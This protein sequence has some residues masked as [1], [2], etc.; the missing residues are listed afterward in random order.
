MK[1]LLLVIISLFVALITTAA[2]LNPYA[3]N[4]SSSYDPSTFTL[5]INYSL[6]APAESVTIVA[7]DSEKNTYTLSQ[8]GAR[9]ASDHTENI[10]LLYS[11]DID[12][13]P[14]NEQLTWRIDVKGKNYNTHQ[15]CGQKISS[16]TPF[17]IGI[18]K[19]P[20]SKYFGRIITSQTNNNFDVGLYSYDPRFQGG[21]VYIDSDVYLGNNQ[22]WYDNTFLTPYRVRI[23]QD[24]SG[25]IFVSSAAVGQPTY[26]WWVNPN[27]LEDWNPLIQSH[28]MKEYAPVGLKNKE[29][30][31]MG[32]IDF[33][34]QVDGDKVNVL[35]FGSSITTGDQ[36][37]TGD[38][39]H[40]G[41]Y[42]CNLSDLSGGSYRAL[43]E[44]NRLGG[45]PHSQITRSNYQSFLNGHAQFDQF[46]GAWF[47]GYGVQSAQFPESPAL[48]HFIDGDASRSQQY[49]DG[50]YIKRKSVGSASIC[51]NNTFDRF[52]ISQG[53][54]ANEARIYNIS[55]ANG[56][57]PVLSDG[58]SVDI[59]TISGTKYVIDM[60]WD[61]ADNLYL[62]VRNRDAALQGVWVVAAALNGEATSTPA[63]VNKGCEFTMGCDGTQYAVTATANDISFGK[64]LVAGTANEF[65]NGDYAACEKLSLAPLPTD[66]HR[67][68]EWRDGNGNVVSSDSIYSFYVSNPTT[69][70]A[71]FEYATYNVE[72]YGLFQNKEDITD[73]SLDAERNARL[74]RLFQVEYNKHA[75]VSQ[76]DKGESIGTSGS[77]RLMYHVL[78]FVNDRFTNYDDANKNK[79]RAL[80]EDFLDNDSD[81]SNLYWLGQYIESVVG[82]EINDQEYVN[83][84]G[85][86][87]QSF[88]NR[89]VKSHNADFSGNASNVGATLIGDYKIV[90]FSEKSKPAYWRP[91]W[92][93]HAC[94]LPKTYN[95]GMGLPKDWNW[96]ELPVGWSIADAANSKTI[97]NPCDTWCKW[98]NQAA[99][100]GKLLGWYYDDKNNPTWPTNPTIVRNVDHSGALFATWVE[101]L[102]SEEETTQH[103][104]DAIFLLNHHNGTHDI[105]V[106]RKMQGGMYNT[107]CLPFSATKAQQPAVLQNATIVQFTGVNE[108]LYDESG[109]PVVELQ[110]TKVDDIVAGVPYLVMP[111]TDIT[112]EMTFTNIL[113]GYNASTPL[114]METAQEITKS[115]NNGSISFIGNIHPTNIPAQSLIVVANN[116]LAEVT[117]AG[118]IQHMRGY[119]RIDDAQLQTLSEEGKVY[120]SMRKPTTTSVP[121]APEAEQ[122]AQPKV[123]KIMRNGKIY[124]LRGDEIYT[125]TGA[126]V[127]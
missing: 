118:D 7:I 120:L 40:S 27:N 58:A 123:Q 75:G 61:Y 59:T 78:K 16:H 93:E 122:P 23:L 87:L 38:A 99:N 14:R 32:N 36:T 25:R 107:L 53:N 33:D 4:L 121:L 65:V 11:D 67:F 127:K 95:Y 117:E 89:T 50:D 13:L 9:D 108:N 46:G 85:F 18:D 125:I 76:L 19:N 42:T 126:R 2:D 52:A 113:T 71:V 69:L 119:F 84:W 90:D 70:V 94:E 97:Y 26:L 5:T 82:K 124:I 98:N 34:L 47:C 114:V 30:D 51:Y 54:L 96:Y 57:H 55:Q 102:V 15:P 110:F 1:K 17:S 88:I 91:Y 74:W 86:Y 111:Q 12:I 80:I 24:G 10:Q 45:S 49:A 100:P 22:N 112:S 37:L 109:E 116:R 44:D 64:I 41:I 29:S 28:T 20:N 66:G 3:Y 115:T 106:L 56:A 77:T 101:K 79:L 68:I 73:S 39:L 60:C 83:V 105:K 72:W 104:S 43:T 21:G 8:C 48:V 6:N 62:C 81:P 35:L 31:S 92:T 63:P 103:N